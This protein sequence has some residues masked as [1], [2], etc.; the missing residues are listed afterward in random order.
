MDDS[1]AISFFELLLP[2]FG[3]LAGGGVDAVTP[4]LV[5]VI[6]L[7]ALRAIHFT[8]QE[9]RRATSMIAEAKGLVDG[10]KPAD[11]W[12]RRSEL[13][14]AASRRPA[15]RDAWREFDETL[16]TQ[17]RHLY[18]TVGAAEHFNEHRFAPGLTDN[19]F[20]HAAPSALTTLGLLGTFVGLTVGLGGLDLGSSGDELRAGIQILVDGAAL[21]FTASLWGVGASLLTNVVIRERE[22]HVLAKLHSLQDRID[23]LFP[24]KSPEQSLSDIASSSSESKEALQVLHEKIG[25]A[26]QESVQHVGES[27]SRAVSEAIHASLAPIMVDLA[28][29][30]SK[31]S[32]AVFE[33]VSEQLTAS[34]YEMGGALAGELRAS[35]TAMR[36]TLDQLGEQLSTHA[37]QHLARM[38]EL[39]SSAAAQSRMVQQA[40][41]QALEAFERAAALH[42]ADLRTT[43][44][45][46][47]AEL[48][49]ATSFQLQAVTDATGRQLLL[50]D[51][52]L[53]QIV[54]ALDRTAV[55]VGAATA[56][57]ESV[58]SELGHVSADIGV[59]SAMLAGALSDSLGRVG[60]LAARTTTT[61]E[62]LAEQRSAMADLAERTV[63]AAD[64][65]QT[66][67]RALSGGFD[68]L[69][70]AQKVFL[71]DLE[72]Q[73]GRHSQA[74]AGW[75]AAYADEVGKQT[76]Y[77]MG[78]WNAQTEHFTSRMLSATEAL[79]QAID[80]I[81]AH[82]PAV[83]MSVVG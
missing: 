78:E 32:A 23:Q 45:Q 36:T 3:D 82:R 35:S 29:T 59:N 67:S 63:T 65:L 80:E 64:L 72:R 24:L 62:V 44:T 14:A 9:S 83:G 25:S 33:K 69:S 46:Q 74:M 31:Q 68:G 42:L 13:Q 7:V 48:Q 57:M 60:E 56:G 12:S 37:E 53:P 2:R 16:V 21:G 40:S 27:T 34:F 79:S 70:A 18:S 20:L 61:A 1:G 66:A 39:Q 47:V 8:M 15:V 58:T 11:L 6:C 41:T 5:I 52:S 71:G 19:R 55:L 22:R 4:F 73:L 17:D 50:L 51:E 49:E 38:D 77:R 26:L 76:A 54:A 75:L 43:T 81:G 10:W 30:A 28:Q